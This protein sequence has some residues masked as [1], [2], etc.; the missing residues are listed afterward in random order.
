MGKKGRRRERHRERRDAGLKEME[1][2]IREGMVEFS[3]RDL[4]ERL[5]CPAT[6]TPRT[7]EPNGL[8]CAQV[9]PPARP[10]GVSPPCAASGDS[11][12]DEACGN[13]SGGGLRRPDQ[14]RSRLFQKQRDANPPGLFGLP[15]RTPR[16]AAHPLRARGAADPQAD[17]RRAS[18]ETSLGQKNLSRN[19]HIRSPRTFS[20]GCELGAGA[21]IQNIIP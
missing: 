2:D 16:R 9:P 8:W 21:A 19:A 6:R 4:V 18:N 7:C 10:R 12:L 5:G 13:R 1:A 20:A 14:V 11:R 3:T 15:R 17:T